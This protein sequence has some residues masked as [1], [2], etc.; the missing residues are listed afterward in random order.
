MVEDLGLLA[1]GRDL[2]PKGE[3]EALRDRNNEVRSGLN[4]VPNHLPERYQGNYWLNRKSQFHCSLVSVPNLIVSQGNDQ[5]ADVVVLE[6]G[7]DDGT[8]GGV[9]GVNVEKNE[10]EEAASD[11]A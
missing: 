2:G 10:G 3:K 7:Y 1:C 8:G 4:R 5:S 11:S 6:S 9:D